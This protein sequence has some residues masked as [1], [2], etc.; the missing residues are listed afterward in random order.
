MQMLPVTAAAV[1]RRWHLP[2]PR[3]ENLFDPAV[4]VPLGAAYLRELLD[5]R[6]GQLDLALAAYNAGPGPVARWQPLAAV[7][8]DVWI[9][10]IPYNETRAYVQHVLEH[11]VAFAWVRDAEPPRLEALLPPV[12]PAM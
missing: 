4:S 7:D 6:A 1:A 10:N 8:A 12:T 3:R 5:R 11:I 2:V 9:E